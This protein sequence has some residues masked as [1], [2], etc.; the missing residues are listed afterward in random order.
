M[1]IVSVARDGYR[2]A[3]SKTAQRTYIYATLLAITSSVLYGVSIIGYLAFYRE[4]VPHQ[5]RSA[6]VH[7]QY[8]PAVPAI[9][10]TASTK[11]GARLFAAESALQQQHPN[12]AQHVHHPYA[13]TDLRSLGLKI[14]QDYDVS[15]VLSLP[16]TPSNQAVGNFMVEIALA[17]SSVNSA[18]AAIVAAERLPPANPRDFL[19]SG[20][21]RL[22]FA[23]AR[24][25]LMTYT[26]PLVA[27]ATRL[28]LL[29]LHFFA[30]EAASRSRLIVPMAE[31]LSFSGSGGPS[32]V[33]PAVL[34]LE[35]RTNGLQELQTYSA[36]VVFA[37]RLSG[38]R[39]LMYHHRVF[40]FL[41]LTTTWWLVEV[42]FMLAVFA[43]LGLAFGGRSDDG[44]GSS[45]PSTRG[46]STT[47]RLD[48]SQRP[49]IKSDEGQGEGEKNGA[50][51]RKTP[52]RK[53]E[54][55]PNIKREASNIKKEDT[56]SFETEASQ[57]AAIPPK[58]VA[59]SAEIESPAKKDNPPKENA[60]KEPPHKENSQLE[61]SQKESPRKEGSQ[62]GSPQKERSPKESTSSLK[63]ST[64]SLKEST[65]SLQESTASLGD[66][67]GKAKH[68]KNDS[69]AATSSKSN[70]NRKTFADEPPEADDDDFD[71]DY[72]DENFDGRYED[73][74]DNEPIIPST[75]SR[76]QNKPQSVRSN[77]P[78]A[79]KK[80]GKPKDSAVA[81]GRSANSSPTDGPVRQRPA[82]KES[83]SLS[84]ASSAPGSQDSPVRK[85]P[86]KPQEDSQ[87]WPA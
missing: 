68:A 15:V 67:K 50:G 59:P 9:P 75:P 80:S 26:D 7:L 47:P 36:E 23:A 39:W 11:A 73:D 21:K 60:Q 79:Q 27:Q 44:A 87:H 49:Q 62:N 85:K 32:A 58:I 43:M 63:E 33:L 24:P 86:Q 56:D 3:T 70:N 74:G 46:S 10:S 51:D 29:P 25:A 71:N 77:S 72:S 45:R 1:S 18:S 17:A 84:T 78:A 4:Y 54:A 83:S 5:V 69:Q 64:S 53:I 41:L 61:H 28:T 52:E 2:A 82:K 66:S 35:L 38:L 34:Y 42:I 19:E 31:S 76:K 6:P 12:G 48:S 22:L 16:Q 40:S 55:P 30:P 65:S 37:A 81:T 8:G 57:L 14:D 20:G 13:L